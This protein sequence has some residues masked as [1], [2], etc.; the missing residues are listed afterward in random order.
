MRYITLHSIFWADSHVVEIRTRNFYSPQVLT[1][2][3]S[4]N[5]LNG[6]LRRKIGRFEKLFPVQGRQKTEGDVV[7]ICCCLKFTPPTFRLIG[8]FLFNPSW[9]KFKK[10][11]ICL[12]DIFLLLTIQ[13]LKKFLKLS[14]TF[15]DDWD[16]EGLVLA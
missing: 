5:I 6:S 3:F 9:G 12:K 10:S 4:S 7:S 14:Q 11:F 16:L 1:A 15:E 13:N 8:T 2:N